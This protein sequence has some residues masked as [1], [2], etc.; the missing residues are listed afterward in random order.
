MKPA[1]WLVALLG[2]TLGAVE[3]QAQIII[4]A[5]SGG[6]TISARGRIGR[7]RISVY[8]SLYGVGYGYGYTRINVYQVYSTP[9][10]IIVNGS[11]DPL[12]RRRR[13]PLALEPADADDDEP[14]PARRPERPRR[15]RPRDEEDTPPPPRRPPEREP[16]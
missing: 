11:V 14:P 8:G 3:A 5:A 15:P 2:V 16:E 7:G 6:I 12:A 1:R 13:L 10:I 4:S 9:S